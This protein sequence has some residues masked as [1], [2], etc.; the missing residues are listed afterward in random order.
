MDTEWIFLDG[1][2]IMR[3]TMAEDTEHEVFYTLVDPECSALKSSDFSFAYISKV[4]NSNAGYLHEFAAPSFSGKKA[5]KLIL[6]VCRNEGMEELILKDGSISRDHGNKNHGFA[7]LAMQQVMSKGQ[8]WYEQLG[9]IPLSNGYFQKKYAENFPY[10]EKTMI[11]L[12]LYYQACSVL[13]NISPHN[14]LNDLQERGCKALSYVLEECLKEVPDAHTF[15]ELYKHLQVSQSLHSFEEHFL[16]SHASLFYTEARK[17]FELIDGLAELITL[18]GE[19]HMAYSG[20]STGSDYKEI[21]SEIMMDKVFSIGKK[22]PPEARLSN[23][24]KDQVSKTYNYT[25]ERGCSDPSVIIDE[26]ETHHC[27]QQAIKQCFA[28]DV[29]PYL[30]YEC[31]KSIVM[32]RNMFYFKL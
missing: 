25:F 6:E 30:R 14:L 4:R 26:A 32:M 31:A 11:P 29:A 8:S 22:T 10:D 17:Y 18:E 16:M 23:C 21:S 3:K 13:R 28:E 27:N 5:L 9:A 24:S 2:I 12:E 1:E 15:A 20:G 7:P 19:Q